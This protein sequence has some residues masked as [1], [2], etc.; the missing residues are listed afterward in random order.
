MLIAVIGGDLLTFMQ[1]TELYYLLWQ[2]LMIAFELTAI[3]NQ[4]YKICSALVFED[5]HP[6][7]IIE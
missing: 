7:E 2:G 4:D 6:V 1:N 3:A 5:V